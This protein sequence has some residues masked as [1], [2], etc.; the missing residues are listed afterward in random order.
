MNK[1]IFYILA[2]VFG[3]SFAACYSFKGISLDPDAKSFSVE[4]FKNNTSAAPPTLQ[5]TFSEKLKDKVRGNTRL[6][7]TAASEGDLRFS[8]VVSRYDVVA[9]ATQPN[10]AAVY[11]QLVIGVRVKYE[12]PKKEK[13]SWEQEFK[14]QSDFPASAS[15]VSVQDELIRVI[16]NKIVDDI[17]NKAFTE[18][19]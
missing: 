9:V 16:S 18:N 2:V 14:F 11:N 10:Q 5:Q 17:F 3:V 7:L 6:K 12:N 1:Y 8:G 13:E 19:W 15:I 4:L